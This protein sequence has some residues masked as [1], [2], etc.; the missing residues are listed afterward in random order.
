MR[1]K[2]VK[3]QLVDVRTYVKGNVAELA[4]DHAAALIANGTAVEVDSATPLSV[5]TGDAAAPLTPPAPATG[6]APHLSPPPF[7]APPA[8]RA[9]V[10]APAAAAKK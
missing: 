5:F 1:V 7:V 2:F 3:S 10:I 4:E 9:P 6:V 8:P